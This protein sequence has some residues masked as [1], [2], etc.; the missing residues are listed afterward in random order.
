MMMIQRGKGRG[1]TEKVG[2][3]VTLAK[4]VNEGFGGDGGDEGFGLV[5]VAAGAD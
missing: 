5:G 4:N 2:I 3:V 1:G